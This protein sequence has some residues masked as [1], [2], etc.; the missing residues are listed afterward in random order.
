MKIGILGTRGIPNHYGGFEQFAEILSV[1]LVKK[2]HQVWVYNSHNHPFQENNYEGV[3]I[4][5]CYDPEYRMGTAGQFIYDFNCIRDARKR[6]FDVL[7]QLG[8]TS[9]SVWSKWLP[10]NQTIVTNMDGLEWK[11]S[12]YRKPI[13]KF[14]LKAEKWAIRSSDF[15]IADSLGIKN[16]IKTKYK[17]EAHF[18]PY[19][20]YIFDQ[21]DSEAIKPFNIIP[22]AYSLLIARMEPE[23]SIETILDGVV[24]SQMNEPFLVIGNIETTF[25]KYLKAKF[26]SD[27]RIQF[28]GSIYDQ[29]L[30]N[31]LRYHSRLY[32]HGHQVGGTNPSLL[33]AMGSQALIV[34]HD[35][36]FNQTVLQNDGFYFKT[37]KEVASHLN[38]TVKSDNLTMIKNNLIK[39]KEAYNWERIISTYEAFFYEVLSKAKA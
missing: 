35:N 19:G 37:P 24:L 22:D 36:A 15:L 9:S 26:T 31:Q 23:N 29:A 2:G 18:I 4:I 21:P 11:R 1:G 33:E 3:S 38:K 27:S 16:Y 25:G 32:F 14:L 6:T 12:K 5:K 17:Q 7:L 34:A 10:K 28:L 13:Q 39:I 30:L 8:Y 20:A